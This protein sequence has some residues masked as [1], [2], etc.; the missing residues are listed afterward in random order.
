[1]PRASS[2]RTMIVFAPMRG[3]GTYSAQ[4]RPWAV[5]E[6]PAH[7]TMTEIATPRSQP[8]RSTVRN[9][10][11]SPARPT[12]ES[13]SVPQWA[14]G[15]AAR[16]DVHDGGEA[17]DDD[18]VRA[19]AIAAPP[20]GAPLGAHRDS[21]KHE[22]HERAK[23]GAKRRQALEDPAVEP[24]FANGHHLG[25][26]QPWP[27]DAHKPRNTGH[28]GVRLEAGPVQQLHKIVRWCAWNRS[29]R[30]ARADGGRDGAQH[31]HHEPGLGGD[32]EAAQQ[33]PPLHAG[34]PELPQLRRA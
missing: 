20:G 28:H 32:A 11:V 22:Q 3:L 23:H 14:R 1:M 31:L 33:W 29:E 7:N 21:R 15:A 9:H 4:M 10:A 17:A 30:C 27:V 34:G 8:R 25:A 18:E 2:D 16:D 6:T 5:A 19:E 26:E 12:I 24:E 13:R